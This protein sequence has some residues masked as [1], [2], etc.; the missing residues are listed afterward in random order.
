MPGTA[1]FAAVSRLPSAHYQGILT[2]IAKTH[3]ARRSK[4]KEGPRWA[5]PV[6]CHLFIIFVP[7]PFPE[8]EMREKCRAPR[9]SQPFPG[10]L[11]R[12]IRV[13]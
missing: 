4:R 3:D 5:P 9:V 6:V 1:G 8:I 11:Q 12:T 10:F 13:F 7:Q 2:T